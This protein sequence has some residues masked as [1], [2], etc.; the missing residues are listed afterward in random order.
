MR[1]VLF[2]RHLFPNAPAP[3]AGAL[4]DKHIILIRCGPTPPP[5]TEGDHQVVDT[6]V[7][8]GTERMHQRCGRFM[9]VV[10]R[11]H[12]QGPVVFAQVIVAFERTVTDLP[13]SILMADKAAIDLALH[14][15]SCQFVRA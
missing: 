7:R 6:P 13:F 11:L 12:Q 3:T 4:N 15:Q 14:G 5:G 2:H 9:P 10:N 8:Q 1:A